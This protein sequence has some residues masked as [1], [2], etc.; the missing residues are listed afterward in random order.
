MTGLPFFK[1]HGL[2]NDFVI[3]DLRSVCGVALDDET[4]RRIANRRTGLG[5]DQ[6]ILLE[7]AEDADVGMRIRNADGSPAGACGNAARCV[8][9]LLLAERQTDAVTIA[10]G[11]RTL[12]ARRADDGAIAVDMGAPSFDWRDIPLTRAVPTDP[13]PLNFTELPAAA[14]VSVGNPH[15]VFFVPDVEEW[16]LTRIAEAVLRDPLLAEGANVSLVARADP[17]GQAGRQAGGQEAPVTLHMRVFERGVGPTPSCGSAAVA[18]AALAHRRGLVGRRV[19]VRQPGG[20]LV[21]VWDEADHLWL[22]GPTA[23]VARGVL[24]DELF[25]SVAAEAA[26]AEGADEVSA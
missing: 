3:I 21:V 11:S 17:G 8:G 2:G 22:A 15:V 23:L 10:V 14:A 20:E 26:A 7:P 6:L 25:D 12:V 16:P 4:V 19:C 9:R 18:A 5:C 1:M 24:A 13:L